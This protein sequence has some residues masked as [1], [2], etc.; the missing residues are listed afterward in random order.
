MNLVALRLCD[1]DSNISYYDGSEVY[2]Y[3]FERDLQIKHFGSNNPHS[4][5]NTIKDVWN[6]HEEDI[7]EIAIVIDPWLYGNPAS[8][9]NFFPATN[10][11]FFPTKCKVI[12]VNHHLAH[13]L[14]LWPLFHD[15][16]SYPN[17][18]F[19]FDGEG[20][21][22]VSWTVIKDNKIVDIGSTEKNGSI[23]FGMFDA[24]KH[25]KLN[26]SYLDMAGKVMGL[27]SYG[28]VDEK[29]LK[30]LSKFDI[31]SVKEIFNFNHW[32]RYAG[33]LSDKKFDKLNWIRT[34]HYYVEK[35][36]IQHFKKFVSKNEKFTYSGGVAQNVIWNTA[37]RNEFPNVIIPPH[38]NDEGL[39]LG[40]LEWLRIKNNLSSFSIKNFPFA[41]SDKSPT[42][43]PSVDTI[44]KVA[45][46]LKEGK[47][48]AWY[49]GNGEIGPRALGNRSILLDP[50][51][52]DGKEKINLIKKRE[53]FRPFGASILFEEKQNYFTDSLEDK[54]MLFT[55]KALY[56]N[57]PAITHVDKTCRVQTVTMENGIFYN[58]LLTFYK[59]TGCP[60]LL[61][62]SLNLA[63]KPLCAFPENALE[64]F[65]TTN[66]DVLV[67]GND[68]Y[69]K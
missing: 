62:T 12:R 10:Y 32:Y 16:K 9:V 25:F 19:V 24:G 50:R 34:V 17:T 59:I 52:K 18:H 68:I 46:F 20:D 48:V 23:G 11:P 36:I 3:K 35:I 28:S 67:I 54:F 26:G 45:N 65:Q 37:I 58:L 69:I 40:A 29:Y 4:W 42:S 63:G 55:S 7:D 64:F 38:S 39:S 27:Q 8:N 15:E 51:M 44:T 30:F 60:V 22:D 14:S 53:K 56:D 43:V 1:H 41:Q 2:Y 66:I 6:L 33:N 47:I 21:K 57:L 61:N 49:Q 13:A 5:K 31:Y